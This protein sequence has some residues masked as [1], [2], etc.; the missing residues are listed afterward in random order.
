MALSALLLSG[1]VS[2]SNDKLMVHMIDLSVVIVS[3]NTADILKRCL[4]SIFN[5]THSI[6]FEVI[7]VDNDSLDDSVTVAEQFT[8][9]V[10]VIKNKENSGFAKAVNKGLE[11]ARGKYF[12]MLNPDC[13]LTDNTFDQCVFFIRKHDAHT[14]MTCHIIDE[15]GKT[16]RKMLG[17]G[18]LDLRAQLVMYLRAERFFG[19]FSFIKNA[20]IRDFDYEIV[21]EIPFASGCFFL[22]KSEFMREIRGCDEQFSL[23]AEDQDLCLR[24]YK[25]GGRILFFPGSFVI[26]TGNESTRKVGLIAFEQMLLNRY[27]LYC[28]HYGRHKA[29]IYKCIRFI[30]AIINLFRLGKNYLMNCQVIDS[31]DLHQNIFVILWCLNLRSARGLPQRTD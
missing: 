27:L 18:F 30:G 14:A 12:L 29:T 11:I 26:H 15:D 6:S 13:I 22:I 17:P 21:R 1:W 2:L 25:H 23:Y 7:V 8:S 28:K 31:A 3:Y 19:R 10:K 5:Q 24:I 4:Q 20:V 16:H 9:H